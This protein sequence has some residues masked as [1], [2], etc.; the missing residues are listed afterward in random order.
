VSSFAQ[1]QPSILPAWLQN[2]AGL[3]WAGVLGNLKDMVSNA[4]RGAA[5]VGMPYAGG[6]SD[7]LVAI[8]FERQLQRGISESDAAYAERLRLAWDAWKRAGSALGI[9]LQL[10]VLYPGIPIVI[11][12]QAHRAYYLNPNTSLDPFDRLVVVPLTNGWRFDANGGLPLSEGFWSRFGV[13][14][15]GP[16]PPTW[17]SIVSPPTTVSDPDVNE[18]NGIIN[19]INKWKP[20]KA[21]A[22]WI[23]VIPSGALMWGWPPSQLWGGGGLVWGGSASVVTWNVTPYV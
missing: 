22:K 3:D 16:L 14:F 7:A 6:P 20:A 18:V 5:V 8:G 23:K 19:V 4:A 11:V 12:Q 1:Y 15:P 2:Q 13:I 10:E 9:L 17:T 21:T